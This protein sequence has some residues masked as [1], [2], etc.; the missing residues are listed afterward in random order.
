MAKPSQDHKR[1]LHKRQQKRLARRGQAPIDPRIVQQA[2]DLI[3]S[4]QWN[5]AVKLLEEANRARPGQIDVMLRLMEVYHELG[6][7]DQYCATAERFAA[8]S[9]TNPTA[10]IALASGYMAATRPASALLAFQKYIELWPDDPLSVG[11]RETIAQLERVLDEML[12]GTPFLPAER[13]ELAAMHEGMLS[14]LSAG[15]YEQVIALGQSLLARCP[16]FVPAMNNLTQAYWQTGNSAEAIAMSQRVLAGDDENF[17]AL[18]NLARLLLLAGQPA[19]AQGMCERLRAARSDNPDIWSKKAET[20]SYFGDDR[21]VLEAFDEARR[22]GVTQRE[23][24]DVALLFHLAAVA[25]AR[26]GNW[27]AAQDYWRRAIKIRPSLEMAEANL[28]DSKQPV[29]ERQGPW[30]FG[31]QYWIRKGTI[32][33]LAAGIE[34][35]APG[36]D[37]IAVNLAVHRFA[38]EHHEL[39]VLIPHLLDRGD[40]SGRMFAW[41]L[42]KTLDTPDTREALRDFCISQRGPDDLR[43]QTANYLSLH[44]VF[45]DGR[46]RLWLAGEW[47]EI[48]CMGFEITPE[49]MGRPHAPSVEKWAQRAVDALHRGDGQAAEQ[50]LRKCLEKEPDRPELLNNLAQ[51]FLLQGRDREAESLVRQI[52]ERWPDYFFGRVSMA[53]LAIKN[54]RLDEAEAY[55]APLR[56]QKRLHSTEFDALAQG[57]I[58]LMIARGNTESARSWLSMWRQIHPEHPAIE[59]FERR[60]SPR[61]LR[62]VFSKLLGGR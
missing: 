21:G 51:T 33:S 62:N 54:C 6:D 3:E 47:R 2:E 10:Q 30:P 31:M 46:V 11:A 24:A 45:P 26:Q 38:Q 44:D 60:L 39:A 58:E 13:V 50:W 40:E 19:E 57:Y 52:H 61:G 22:L 23:S 43:I 20:F 32:E 53:N 59:H 28:A 14:H 35:S 7:F 15:K 8:Q 17:H 9:P 41:R 12:E 5:E 49:R 25:T 4:G 16:G 56:R 18:A 37:D 29:G 1:A 27:R 55:L 42:A 34:K 48:E 36:D